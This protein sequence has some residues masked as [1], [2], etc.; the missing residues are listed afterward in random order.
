V[1]PGNFLEYPAV[2]VGVLLVFLSFLFK[3]TIVPFHVWA[4]DVFKGMPPFVAPFILV[5][6]KFTI[7]CVY[8]RLLFL[9]NPIYET[10]PFIFD[11]LDSFSVT[12][13]GLAGLFE[14]NILRITA[15]S[16]IVNIGILLLPVQSGDFVAFQASLLFFIIYFILLFNLFSCVFAFKVKRSLLLRNLDDLRFISNSYQLIGFLF[17]VGMFSFV[18]IPPLAGF[19]PKFFALY[20]VF[21]DGGFFMASLV[22]FC[23][24]ISAFYYLDFIMGLFFR[25]KASFAPCERVSLLSF[26]LIFA[27]SM[28]NIFFIIYF[29]MLNH[30]I[31]IS[32]LDV[33]D[34]WLF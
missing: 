19:F 30:W 31:N 1:S 3:F 28:F 16:S 24:A 18:G 8:I 21:E 17:M 10:F 32:L 9:L 2:V 25:F 15:F 13:G 29:P 26:S 20:T 11:I 4:A 7:L 33:F 12:I 34:S 27:S 6:P 14:A 23:S 5:L 22:L